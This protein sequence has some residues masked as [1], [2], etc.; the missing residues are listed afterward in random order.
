M[1]GRKT[2]FDTGISGDSS[3]SSAYVTC[4][5]FTF[6]IERWLYLSWPSW[7]H[8]SRHVSGWKVGSCR[9]RYRRG[10]SRRE[11]P[12]RAQQRRHIAASG[13]WRRYHQ[14]RYTPPRHFVIRLCGISLG[15][16]VPVFPLLQPLHVQ[17]FCFFR[18]ILGFA[19][20]IYFLRTSI[21]MEF[22]CLS[23][24]ELMDYMSVGFNGWWRW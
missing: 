21:A 17:L 19:S 4:L 11:I 24:V 2:E 23:C 6:M 22:G 9:W 1:A 10:A 8:A 7:G 5:V 12:R 20:S 18:R 15:Y 16:R 3:T 14:E 13:S